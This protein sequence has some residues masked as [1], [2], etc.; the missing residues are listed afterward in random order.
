MAALDRLL[1]DGS[2]DILCAPEWK[3]AFA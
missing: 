1:E 3:Q 2:H